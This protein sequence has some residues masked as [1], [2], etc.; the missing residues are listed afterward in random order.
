MKKLSILTAILAILAF[1]FG[2]LAIQNGYDLFQKALAKE[3]AEGNLEEAI[4]LYQKV[5]VESKDE[6]L[7]AK[8]QLRIGICYEKLGQEKAK[9]A[10]EA[11]QKVVDNYPRQTE[12]VRTARQKLSGILKAQSVIEKGDTE[13]KIRKIWEGADVDITGSVSP[14]GKYV[15]YAD[16]K[17]G[18]LAVRELA[19]GQKRRL[20][21]NPDSSAWTG[22]SV[23]SPDG[24]QIAFAWSVWDTELRVIGLDGS[25]LRTLARNSDIQPAG[26]T[27]D[28]RH[29]LAIDSIADKTYRIVLVSVTDGAIH[30]LKTLGAQTP[31]SWMSF[32][33]DGRYIVYDLPQ[34]EDSNDRDI[35]LLAADGTRETRLIEH[36]SN[37][38][39]LGWTP[40]G[41][42]LLF[43]SNR[44]GSVG[45]WIIQV[46]DGQPQGRPELVKQD[47]GVIRSLGITKNG[48]FF[49][50]N[51]AQMT[52]EVCL[53]N[54]DPTTQK[55]V[56]AVTPLSQQFSVDSSS[57]DWSSDGKFLAFRT[58]RISGLATK[59]SVFISIRSLETGEVRELS[60]SMKSFYL[61]KWSP[62]GR[63]LL[64]VGM[65][66]KSQFG[67]HI[68]DAQT[69]N[70]TATVLDGY[71]GSWSPDGKAI[72]YAKNDDSTKS[73]P[74]VIR[75]LKSGE[76]KVL[77]QGYV[78]LCVAVS[79]DGGQVAFSA[80]SGED[81]G[82]LTLHILSLKEGTSRDIF[83]LNNPEDF[84][85]I[86]WSPAGGRL[87]FVRRNFKK[88][89]YEVWQIPVKG[90]E[91]QA[92]G[93]ST[94]AI[95][96]ISMHP[97]G[98]RIAFG[99]GQHKAE[100]WMMEN[101]LPKETKKNPDEK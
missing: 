83:R 69:G 61:V 15:S 100:M 5:I 46:A 64:L 2:S 63:S 29:I 44:T 76:D 78:G 57:P 18:D 62:D 24:K 42:R 28:G 81:Y 9:L 49:F 47:L 94:T 65:N 1:S 80:I 6:S 34:Q 96:P 68:V 21:T 25:N 56:G 87:M 77:F 16:L 14:D 50:G 58:T 66:D 10:Q 92:V 36:P 55:V 75:D 17:S 101:F 13:F 43:A 26:W 53:A 51:Y 90:G 20:T 37:D 33:P 67:L 8:A 31:R 7:A 60:P 32:S 12:I 74:L 82:L 71:W 91:P 95:S 45:A 4:A 59:P 52:R 84:G 27:P 3:R 70:L 11:F 54:L 48:T 97:D 38:Y 88:N 79:P 22:S 93:L 35:F 30:P 40:D 85:A 89:K 72:Y 99:A 23:F 73:R 19:T 98:K 86:A 41:T 39:V